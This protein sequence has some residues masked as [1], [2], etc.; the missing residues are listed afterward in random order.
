M[1]A[2]LVFL[3]LCAVIAVGVWWRRSAVRRVEPLH[4]VVLSS[5]D[6]LRAERYG[7]REPSAYDAGTGRDR[8]PTVSH[9]MMRGGSRIAHTPG[10]KDATA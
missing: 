2:P 10:S 8:T 4:P 7:G 9:R 6:L 3:S 5:A 1:I